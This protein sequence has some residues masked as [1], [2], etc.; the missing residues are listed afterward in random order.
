M[1]EAATEQEQQTQQQGT[2]AQQQEQ[3]P[4]EET[5]PAEWD[6]KVESLP[7]GAQKLINELRKADGDERVAKKTLDAIQKA[8]NPEAKDGEK[9]DADA[10]TRSLTEQQAEARQAK[11]ELAVYKAANTLGADADAL[12]DSRSFL[13]K[14]GDIDPTKTADI[15]KAIK[16]AVKDNPKLKAAR[17]AGTSGGDFTGGTGEKPAKPSTLEDAIAKKMAR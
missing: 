10:L 14:L 7:A 2:E 11:T 16:D 1:S 4:A 8:L 6:G 12:L 17:A 3:K 15:E 9:P 13:A 5:K